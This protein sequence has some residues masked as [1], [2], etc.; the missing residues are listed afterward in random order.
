MQL[1][2]AEA[3]LEDVVV[4]GKGGNGAGAEGGDAG[5]GG[6]RA[7]VRVGVWGPMVGGGRD[8]VCRDEGSEG[9]VEV[10][11]RRCLGDFRGAQAYR[12]GRH[13]DR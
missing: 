11:R 10:L 4:E 13:G 8:G 6:V 9:A 7:G 1:G 12:C 2:V 5:G 3:L